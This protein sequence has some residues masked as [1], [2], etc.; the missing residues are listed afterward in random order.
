VHFIDE[1]AIGDLVTVELLE[2]GPNSI[3]GRKV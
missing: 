3:V 2:A 1:A